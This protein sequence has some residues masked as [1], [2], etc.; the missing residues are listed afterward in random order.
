MLPDKRNEVAVRQVSDEM[1]HSR[2]LLAAYHFPP[3]AAVGGLRISRFARFL[4][5]FGWRPYVLTV[6]DADRDDKEGTDHSRLV[7]LDGAN[8]KMP[9]Q[10]S[11][12]MRQRVA[13]ARAL[14]LDPQVLRM[15]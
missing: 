4:P 15:D 9:S 5:E 10:L 3:S 1:E 2:I 13:I 14:A 6:K 8:D 7:G 11:G 12:G